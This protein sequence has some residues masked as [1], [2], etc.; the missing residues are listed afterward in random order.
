MEKLT[1]KDL[2]DL[3]AQNTISIKNME[4][5]RIVCSEIAY[6]ANNLRNS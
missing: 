4:K 2:I 6:F 1:I 5:E 3:M